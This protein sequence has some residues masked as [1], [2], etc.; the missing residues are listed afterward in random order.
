MPPTLIL[1]RRY[2]SESPAH[3]DG[4]ATTDQFSPIPRWPRCD[5]P[6]QASLRRRSGD[7]N[8]A[9]I[10][11]S[12]QSRCNDGAIE[13]LGKQIRVGFDKQTRRGVGRERNPVGYGQVGGSLDDII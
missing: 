10:V 3:R 1:W 12:S 5:C 13:S 7:V 6:A 2:A 11:S 8:R 4:C 9:V